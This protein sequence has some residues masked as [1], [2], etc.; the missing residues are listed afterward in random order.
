MAGRA[1]RREAER[2]LLEGRVR[3]NGVVVAELGARVV[4]GEDRVSVDGEAVEFGREAVWVA[5]HKPAGVLTT[6]SDPHGGRTVYDVLPP[7]LSGLRYLGRLDR[8]TEGLLLLSN[9][10]D[11]IHAVTHPRGEVERE[12]EAWV[13]G[14]PSAATLRRLREGVTLGDGPA[15]AR[16][17]EVRGTVVGGAVVELVLTEGRKR[18]V[19]RLLEAVGHPVRRLVRVRFGPV[20]L[21]DLPMGAWRPLTEREISLL[22]A[23][24][25]GG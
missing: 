1:S 17:A 24:A 7:E 10:G 9:Q 14:V 23:L 4:P 25:R 16:R 12:Y 22:E 20:E 15:R 18:E 21:G 2:L 11:A 5:F 6:R 19:R 3:V 13:E 8:D